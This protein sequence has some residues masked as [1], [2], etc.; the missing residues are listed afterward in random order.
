MCSDLNALC[1]KQ[2]IAMLRQ[3]STSLN[4]SRH[5]Y[6]R[7]S[8]SWS[9]AVFWFPQA[10]VFNRLGETKVEACLTK[11]N[12]W[13]MEKSA[14][15]R[16]GVCLYLPI[17]NITT[18]IYAIDTPIVPTWMETWNWLGCRMKSSTLASCNIF[19]RSQAMCSS[20]TSMWPESFFHRYRLSEAELSSSSMCTTMSLHSLSHFQKCTI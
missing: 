9:S 16:M 13:D 18:G 3:E 6:S 5:V 12:L 20:P 10:Y 7:W 17:V 1:D 15:V 2:N 14:L 8:L 4:K 19:E 11:K